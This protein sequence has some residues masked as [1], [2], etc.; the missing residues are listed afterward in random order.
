MS[1]TSVGIM[2]LSAAMVSILLTVSLSMSMIAYVFYRHFGDP[3]VAAIVNLLGGITMMFALVS[4][5]T[6]GPLWQTIFYFNLF[7]MVLL[8]VPTLVNFSEIS[9]LTK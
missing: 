1:S 2:G 4:M 7:L 3:K 8:T 6:H 9:K 5:A